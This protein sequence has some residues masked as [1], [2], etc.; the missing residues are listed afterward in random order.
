MTRKAVFM[1]EKTHAR[2]TVALA[3]AVAKKGQR[4]TF[5]QFINQLLDVHEAGGEVIDKGV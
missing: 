1:S 5:E 2:L 4:I 3:Q